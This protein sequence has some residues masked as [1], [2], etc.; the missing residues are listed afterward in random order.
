MGIF[1]VFLTNGA[2]VAPIIGGYLVQTAGVRWAYYFPAIVNSVAFI[3]MIFAMPE[4]LFSRSEKVL[5]EHQERTYRQMLFSFRRNALRDRSVQMRDFL[6][7]LEMMY[8]PSI[9]LTCL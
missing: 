1:T 7:P 9:T 2:H 5:V 8:Y 4:T 6:R 3:I